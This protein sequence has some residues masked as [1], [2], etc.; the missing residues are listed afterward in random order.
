MA[1][2]N[3]AAF[4]DISHSKYQEMVRDWDTHMRNLHTAERIDNP[5]LLEKI[6]E[7]AQ[8]LKIPTP[9]AYVADQFPAMYG[10]TMPNAM[11]YTIE[12]PRLPSAIV[13]T[14]QAFL[15]HNY[16]PHS[17]AL[18]PN[19]VLWTLG[20]EM[21]HIKQGG[22]YLNAI[23]TYPRLAGAV[24]AVIGLALLNEAFIRTRK[25]QKE[26]AISDAKIQTTLGEIAEEERQKI[27]SMLTEAADSNKLHGAQQAIAA[28]LS[29]LLTAGE[30]LATAAVGAVSGRFVTRQL[31]LNVEHDADKIGAELCEDPRAGIRQLNVMKDY[32][33][34]MPKT[35]WQELKRNITTQEIVNG[36]FDDAH[37][38]NRERI[39][40]LE[41]MAKQMESAGKKVVKNA[42]QTCET[43]IGAV[44]KNTSL[45]S[46]IEKTATHL[47]L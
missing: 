39:T 14:K 36:Y 42:L 25:A 17:G 30:Y 10:G 28:T 1:M 21:G 45:L 9:V 29:P 4:Y 15:T 13:F 6:S 19:E 38:T 47:H 18:P 20:H 35:E 16:L 33:K 41:T 34:N 7:Y 8:R 24:G 3:P 26:E 22:K 31:V 11:V 40:R 43:A 27:K 2:S 12:N 37:P 46:Q 32:L 23:R 5:Q 44:T